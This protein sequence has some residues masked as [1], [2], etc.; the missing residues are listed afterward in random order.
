MALGMLVGPVPTLAVAVGAAVGFA[1]TFVALTLRSGPPRE[2]F[3]LLVFLMATGLPQDDP[4][5]GNALLVLGGASVGW[6]LI[7]LPALLGRPGPEWRAGDDVL[8]RVADPL[9][10]LGGSDA[11]A[12]RHAAI[13][14]VDRATTAATDTRGRR[15][16]AVLRRAGGLELLLEAALALHA[17]GSPPV[18]RA[19]I[20]AVRGLAADRDG[21]RTT[22]AVPS[23]GL[24]PRPGAPRL[25]E[26]VRLL[27]EDD[28]P[29][30]V[31]PAARVDRSPCRLLS[32][33]SPARRIATRMAIAPAGAWRSGTCWGSRTPSGWRSA[34]S[35][36]SRE[37]RSR[38][39]AAVPCTAPR[40]R[41]S[42]SSSPA[43]CCRSTPGRA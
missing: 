19:W 24:P 20:D 30:D 1:T 15:R 4:V 25:R 18:D 7:M 28:A 27:V 17:E 36:R 29:P 22:P 6:A 5:V 12:A 26:A 33:P 8:A 21:R 42:G 38:W 16:S 43:W 3:V 2:F 13:V 39:P 40:G 32:E 31:A 14:A 34:A 10:A 35:R 37:R 41:S 23:A 9:H 11:V